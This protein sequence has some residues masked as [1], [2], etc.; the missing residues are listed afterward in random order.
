M[1]CI[2]TG[3]PAVTWP[4]FADQQPN[5]ECLVNNGAAIALYRVFRQQKKMSDMLTFKEPIFTAQ[6][7]KEVFTEILNDPKYVNNMKK[8]KFQA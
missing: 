1:E 5:S 7:I 2:T 3:T 4:H 6:K 8:L